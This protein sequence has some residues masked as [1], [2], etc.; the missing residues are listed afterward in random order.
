MK[1]KMP[2]SRFRRQLKEQLPILESE[3]LISP[4]QSQS[5]T[6]RYRLDTLNSE[7][8]GMLLSV[9]YTIGA[10]LIGIGAVSFVAAHWD[11]IGRDTK[12]IM[13]FAVMLAVHLA[14]FFLWQIGGSFPKL[15]HTLVLLG[16]LIFGANI[17]LMAQ[18]FHIQ[19]NPFN[20][21][22]AWSIGAIIIAYATKSVPNAVLAV[23]VAIVAVISGATRYP[24]QLPLWFPLVAMAMFI[25]FIYYVRSRWVLCFALLLLT[26][27][28]PFILGLNQLDEL[29]VIAGFALSGLLFFS[30]ASVSR[31]KE[32]SQFISPAASA[33]GVFNAAAAVYLFS[34]HDFNEEVI[35]LVRKFS[36]A[37]SQNTAIVAGIILLAAMT[38]TILAFCKKIKPIRALLLILI[39]AVFAA[40]ITLPCF[41]SFFEITIAANAILALM[42]VLLFAASFSYEDRRIFWA[43]ALMAALLILT[44]TL[45]YE[46]E[47]LIKA[48]IFTACGVGII[49][50]GVMFE[51][52]LKARR[53]S[54]A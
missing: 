11:D 7:A 32:P 36:F 22:F 54:H 27:T 42:I 13:I 15:G 43:A 5:L 28:M 33:L 23:F 49:I 44:R 14:G 9:I 52:F 18:I 4:E 10:V 30:W 1:D 6:G 31:Q 35:N 46:T 2:S 38:L 53:L 39:A 51:R 50:A 19:S 24:H 29:G 3:G 40:I 34:F 21:F 26:I 20:G 45:E 16:T 47:L 8:T 12:V 25:P 37:K 17:G 41:L 48:I